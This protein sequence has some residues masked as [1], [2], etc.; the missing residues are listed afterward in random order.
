MAL[1][2]F[3]AVMTAA[4]VVLFAVMSVASGSVQRHQT[5]ADA[6]AL[7]GAGAFESY[8]ASVLAAG[9]TDPETDL[10]W[11]LRGSGPCPAVVR[12]EASKYATLND[13]RLIGC[14]MT[15]FGEVEVRVRG[16]VPVGDGRTHDALASASWG[17]SL[18]ECRLDPEFDPEP[19]EATTEPP[20]DDEEPPEEPEGPTP[21]DPAPTW[22]QCGPFKIHLKYDGRVYKVVP[23]GQVKDHIEP[24]LTD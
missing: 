14:R 13:A 2:M 24:R 18:D 12:T 9:F 21:E 17:L 7:A 15:S 3:A 10:P 22:M 23:W 20:E 8:G 4:G 19:P 5:A 6:A 11:L 1:L 16:Q